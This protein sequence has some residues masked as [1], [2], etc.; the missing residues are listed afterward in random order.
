MYEAGPAAGMYDPTMELFDALRAVNDAG[1]FERA[2]EQSV[3]SAKAQGSV[4][5]IS[6]ARKRL[7]AFAVELFE[8]YGLRKQELQ[9]LDE[10][11]YAGLGPLQLRGNLGVRLWREQDD[12]VQFKILRKTKWRGQNPPNGMPA[13]Y[14]PSSFKIDELVERLGCWANAESDKR[15]VECDLRMDFANLRKDS[16]DRY[17]GT[18]LARAGY[19]VGVAL[20]LRQKEA[21]GGGVPG[22]MVDVY[23]Q[24]L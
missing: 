3:L 2:V 5:G 23:L 17:S 7:R 6:D 22:V 13:Y 19:E 14:P 24:P 9:G 12:S 10:Q 20:D 11:M 18:L 1:K 16:Y 8:H 15:V 21:P 4:L